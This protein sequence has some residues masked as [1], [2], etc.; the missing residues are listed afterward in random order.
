M[1]WANLGFWAEK[2]GKIGFVFSNK[3]YFIRG[4][5]FAKASAGKFRGL[6]R[7]LLQMTKYLTADI[8]EELKVM[9]LEATVIFNFSMLTF[10][11]TTPVL[12][13]ILN[14]CQM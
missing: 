7:I 3:L 12:Y 9:V 6:A 10:Y 5:A 14:T 13:H 11:L 1:F 4:P 2:R 8:T